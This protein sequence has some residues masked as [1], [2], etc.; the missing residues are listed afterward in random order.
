[1]QSEIGASNDGPSGQAYAIALSGGCKRGRPKRY[2]WS[3][4]E[5][6]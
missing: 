2:W 3:P 5:V 1:M 6:C 4:Y